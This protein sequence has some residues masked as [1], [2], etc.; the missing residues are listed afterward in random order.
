[1]NVEVCTIESRV[2]PALSAQDKRF[3]Y[4]ANTR[5]WNSVVAHFGSG[6]EAWRIASDLC[7]A[8]LVEVT[9]AVVNGSRLG[10]PSSWRLTAAAQDEARR[11]ASVPNTAAD[12]AR[13]ALDAAGLTKT[14]WVDKW[15]SDSRRSG[16]LRR[17]AAEGTELLLHAAACI[18]ALPAVSDGSPVGRSELAATHGG[19]AGAHALDD[20]H[21]LTALV[22]RAAAAIVGADYPSTSAG[23]RQLWALVGVVSD[24]VS[25]TVLVANLR[26]AGEG[27]LA[28][29]LR[30]RAAARL[31]THLCARD[32]AHETLALPRPEPVFACENPRVLE[33]ALDRGS[34]A[35]LVC[36][37]GSPTIVTVELLTQLTQ[38]GCT[39]AYR[40]DFDWAGIAI[41]NRL[42]AQTGCST[43]LYDTETY[44]QHI[45]E[46]KVE[47][48]VALAGAPVEARWDHELA[49]AMLEAGAAI[50]E[51]AL[52][53]SL[54]ARLCQ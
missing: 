48:R 49:P 23:R 40:G 51:E 24:S 50:H 20:G 17:S 44:V 38:A 7:R 14:E 18:A 15:I 5:R 41:A 54:V 6:D 27:I 46:A 33:A 29:H 53:G 26:P 30:E 16:L 3:V 45:A 11:R 37:Q 31:P 36:V 42:I 39:I 9:C 13:S 28:R 22:L 10:L 19:A 1:M 43:W 52:L 2:P 4:G 21:R 35:A 8:G 25:A 34:T 47:G 32:L 12:V